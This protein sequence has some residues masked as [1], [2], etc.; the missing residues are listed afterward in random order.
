MGRGEE[1]GGESSAPFS[2]K[3]NDCDMQN[4]YKPRC[5][6]ADAFQAKITM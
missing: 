4:V 6:C 2:I 1:G 3:G 5:V